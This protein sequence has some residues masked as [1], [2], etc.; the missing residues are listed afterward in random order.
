[1]DLSQYHQ[2]NKTFMS[3]FA[4]FDFDFSLAMSLLTNIFK[5]QQFAKSRNVPLKDV[6]ANVYNFMR[7]VQARKAFIANHPYKLE[8]AKKIIEARKDKK[9]ITFNSSI[10]QCESYETGYVVHSGNTKKKN[11]MTLEEFAKCDKAIIHS[12]A[13]LKEGLDVP[14]LEVAIVT[15]FNSSQIEKKQMNG[16][17]IRYEPGKQA[18]IFTLVLKGTVEE[19]WFQKSTEEMNYIELTEEDIISLGLFESIPC[20]SAKE[21]IPDIDVE[22]QITK[23]VPGVKEVMNMEPATVIEIAKGAIPFPSVPNFS[24]MLNL[25][26]VNPLNS[27]PSFSSSLTI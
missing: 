3:H 21:V 8:I 13:Q 18:E 12:A 27:L 16:R 20:P 10:K 1:V 14:G 7:V 17:V 9:I 26:D 24:N 6:K 5:Q 22:Q 2:L 23:N 11:R 15:G 4:F 19:K 25:P